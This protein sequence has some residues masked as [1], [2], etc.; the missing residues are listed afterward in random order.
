MGIK[1]VFFFFF[2]N[3]LQASTQPGSSLIYL[4]S[5]P[6]LSGFQPPW[7]SDSSANIARAFTFA[8]W[9]PDIYM[10]KCHL[11][12]KAFPDHWM[13]N[14][15]PL[16]ILFFS[17]FIYLTAGGIF[18]AVCRLSTCACRLSSC[19]WGL[20][21][22]MVCEVLVP[23]TEIELTSPAL[24]GRSLTTGPPGTSLPYQFSGNTSSSGHYLC[25]IWHL[26]SQP[27]SRFPLEQKLH[28][29]RNLA[30]PA[31]YPTRSPQ[32]TTWDL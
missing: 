28:A 25:V 6:W 8:S 15:P 18:I 32:N 26:H 16:L 22:P 23:Q 5:L 11:L 27:I 10:T 31:P 14:I 9:I 21:C 29:G 20:S 3:N 17:I 4:H 19:E 2:N 1:P 7:P 30:C 24:Q 13:G 12:R